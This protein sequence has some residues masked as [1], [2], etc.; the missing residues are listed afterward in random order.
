LPDL[1]QVI[2][3]GFPE[4]DK[5]TACKA[6]EPAGVLEGREKD[7]TTT[8]CEAANAERIAGTPDAS[9]N[10]TEQCQPGGPF[11]LGVTRAREQCDPSLSPAPKRYRYQVQE[12]TVEY[13]WNGTGWVRGAP[14]LRTSFS[15]ARDNDGGKDESRDRLPCQLNDV[16]LRWTSDFDGNDCGQVTT[17]GFFPG[18][19]KD[20]H[21]AG[22]LTRVQPACSNECPPRNPPPKNEADPTRVVRFR[23]VTHVFSCVRE[24]REPVDVHL[25]KE[26]PNSQAK[27]GGNK[28]SPKTIVKDVSLGDEPFQVRTVAIGS[29]T[30]R[31]SARLVRLSLWGKP[32]PTNPLERLRELGGFAFAQ[33]EYYYEGTEG[34]DAWMWNMNWRGRLRRFEIPG[35]DKAYQVL[36][37]TCKNAERAGQECSRVLELL[38]DWRELLIH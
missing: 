25:E 26:S 24:R 16:N 14:D 30:Q 2:P 33:A 23:Q 7:A 27:K 28:K 17:D 9:G 13:K 18:Y 20:V 21:P 31:E 37:A 10:C 5:A 35:D 1:S 11:D 32:D 3:K 34:R 38:E 22:D 4:T 6:S 36:H 19:N 15:N 12:G 8:E 29:N